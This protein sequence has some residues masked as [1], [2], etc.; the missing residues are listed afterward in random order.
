MH[1]TPFLP[2]CLPP[3]PTTVTVANNANYDGGVMR[4]GEY[5]ELARCP[6]GGKRHVYLN[7]TYYTK[8]MRR[9]YYWIGQDGGDWSKAELLQD[10]PVDPE[11]VIVVHPAAVDVPVPVAVPVPDPASMLYLVAALAAAINLAPGPIPIPAPIPV[12]APTPVLIPT[13]PALIEV[14]AILPTSPAPVPVIASPSPTGAPTS[15][16]SRRLPRSMAGLA[17]APVSQAAAAIAPV[18]PLAASLA[19]P[20]LPLA[21]TSPVPGAPVGTMQFMVGSSLLPFLHA[22]DLFGMSRPS[23]SVDLGQDQQE[24]PQGQSSSSS[25]H[26]HHQ[27]EYPQGQSSSSPPHGQQEESQPCAE[28]ASLGG[29]LPSSFQTSTI[30]RLNS[31]SGDGR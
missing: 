24:Y 8:V 1:P 15:S 16:P 9:A 30:F 28:R 3:L 31:F 25:L 22:N 7:K 2:A 5:K 20:L 10:V 4:D 23:S 13:A 29:V 26:R 6:R 21:P 14:G 27:Q 12:L 17:D 18:V 11:Q 19:T